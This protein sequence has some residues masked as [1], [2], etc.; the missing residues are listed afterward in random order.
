MVG[1]NGMLQSRVDS[2]KEDLITRTN[3]MKGMIGEIVDADMTQ[4]VSNLQQAQISVQAA[5]Q[6]FVALK[7]SSLLNILR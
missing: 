4:A 6:V 7:E 1:R 2:V 3:S 5:A